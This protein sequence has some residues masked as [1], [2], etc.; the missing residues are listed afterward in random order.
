MWTLVYKEVDNN[1]LAF[2]YK[3]LKD[4]QSAKQMVEDS[5]GGELFDENG[6]Y[7]GCI[8]LEWCHLI[9]GKL[10]EPTEL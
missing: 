5:D 6:N 7:D 2:T 4:A 3:S 8:E 9:S 1:P 10:I